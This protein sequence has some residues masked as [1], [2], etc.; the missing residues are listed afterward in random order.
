[1]IAT[2]SRLGRRL[3][4]GVSYTIAFAI[5]FLGYEARTGLNPTQ[6]VADLVKVR[7]LLWAQDN[8]RACL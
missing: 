7:V 6:N 8:R 1:M 2:C 4:D 3:F 5:A